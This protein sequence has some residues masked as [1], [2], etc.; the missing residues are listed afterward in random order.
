MS[1]LPI[2]PD[3]SSQL[4]KKPRVHKVAFGDGYEQRTADGLN[5]NPDGWD[6]TWEELTKSEV[7]T[8]MTFF[9]GLAGVTAFTWQSPYAAAAKKY[10]SELWTVTPISDNV[11]N[12]TATIYQVFEP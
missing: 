10:V 11:H 3:Y 12:L 9:D 6:L 8:L 1:D 4:K 5:A 7:L 2:Q